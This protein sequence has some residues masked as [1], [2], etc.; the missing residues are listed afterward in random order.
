MAHRNQAQQ[1]HDHQQYSQSPN[2]Y[3]QMGDQGQRYPQQPSAYQYPPQQHSG[4]DPRS[5]ALGANFNSRYG[6]YSANDNPRRRHDDYPQA[7]PQMR[8][9]AF[10]RQPFAQHYP[11][12]Q[13]GYQD[14]RSQQPY[15]GQPQP[16]HDP[17]YLQWRDEQMQQMDENYQA[18]RQQR[19]AK[20]SNEFGEWQKNQKPEAQANGSGSAS[21]K[22]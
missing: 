16:H 3:P 10:E 12:P 17:D 6:P 8:S 2:P 1:R 22:K 9:E 20:F 13:Q 7:R 15:Q 19:Y 21:S 11:A 14:P 5:D 18:W 4:Y